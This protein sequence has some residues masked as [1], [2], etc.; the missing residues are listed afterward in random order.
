MRPSLFLWAA[1]GAGLVFSGCRRENQWDCFK[2][3]G[4]RT[5]EQREI[6]SF[7]KILAEDNIDIILVQDSSTG[8]VVEAGAN[9]IP[10]IVTE[11]NQGE[12]NIRNENRCNWARS[13]KK[14]NITVTIK[15]PQFKKISHYGTGLISCSD[16]LRADTLV[17]LTHE[18]GN[19]DLL[20]KTKILF[21]QMHGSAD[22]RLRGYSPLHGNYHVGTGYL[23]AEDFV[24]NITWTHTR[25]SG[26]EY[27]NALDE[28]SVTIEWAGDVYYKGQPTL[29]LQGPGPGKLLPI[30]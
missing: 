18:S 2:G 15:G 6:P 27:F 13:Y 20:L 21:T 5:T 11:V 3:T 30:L 10:G 14:G 12:L 25:A 7:D 1:L 8:I 22:V 28:L 16:T 29:N 19:V 26:N 17:L 24:S 23:H 9:L 4:D